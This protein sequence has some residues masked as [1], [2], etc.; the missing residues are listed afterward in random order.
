MAPL[1][2]ASPVAGA[3]E[4]R[5]SEIDRKPVSALRVDL[6]GAAR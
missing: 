6:G 2:T 3:I 5:A 4:A 1:G